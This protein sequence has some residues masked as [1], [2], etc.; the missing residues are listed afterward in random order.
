MCRVIKLRARQNLSMMVRM[1]MGIATSCAPVPHA[2]LVM[3]RLVVLCIPESLR[4]EAGTQNVQGR[5]TNCVKELGALFQPPI[6]IC[7][8]SRQSMFSWLNPI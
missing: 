3:W 5:S 2:L 8:M 1:H 4:A 7:M 6:L